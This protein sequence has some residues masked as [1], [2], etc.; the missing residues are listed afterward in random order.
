LAFNLDFEDQANTQRKQW[1]KHAGNTE[2][3]LFSVLR[4]SFSRGCIGA[5]AEPQIHP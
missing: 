1:K 4:A 5:K 2:K 3:K